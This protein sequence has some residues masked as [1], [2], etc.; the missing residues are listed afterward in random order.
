MWKYFYVPT[1]DCFSASYNGYV[2][3]N[4]VFKTN[5]FYDMRWIQ[6]TTEGVGLIETDG[7][8]SCDDFVLL[9]YGY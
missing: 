4:Y 3:A 2:W 9:P 8:I 5:R 7:V 1:N 6:R